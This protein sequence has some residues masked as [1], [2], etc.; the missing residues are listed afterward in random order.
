MEQRKQAYAAMPDC[1]AGGTHGAS[2]NYQ[3]LW[4][5]GEAESGW[6]VNVTHQGDIVFA[7]WFTY[8]ADGRGMWL[9]MPNGARTGPGAYAGALY[10]TTGPPF[11]QQPWVGA[12]VMATEMGHA[13][14]LFADA[15]RGTF[16]YT[17][18]SVTQSKPIVR[19]VYASPA[20]VCR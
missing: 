19:Q 16:T 5:G 3:A 2:P 14:F 10:R 8:D 15:E 4:W 7:T 20:T 1:T 13:S 18:G 9:V 12:A 6:G 17:V 11:S